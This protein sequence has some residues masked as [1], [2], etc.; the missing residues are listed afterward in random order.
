M[1]ENALDTVLEAKKRGEDHRRQKEEKWK[2]YYKLYRSYLEDKR[3]NKANL[4][5]PYMFS[6]IESVVPRLTDTIFRQ[7]PYLR[8][9]PRTLEDKPHAEA[10]E[11]LLDYQIDLM[12]FKAIC[13]SWFKEATIYGTGIAK[14]GWK[15][16]YQTVVDKRLVPINNFMDIFRAGDSG[17]Y[18]TYEHEIIAYDGPFIECVD[19]FDYYVDPYCEDHRDARWAVHKTLKDIDYLKDMQEKGIYE[20]VDEVEDAGKRVDHSATKRLMGIQQATQPGPD[21]GMNEISEYWEKDRVITVANDIV[22][23]R[24]APNPYHHKRLP[25][26][27]VVNT[28]VP[29]EFWGIGEVEPSE[30]LQNELNTLRN[31]AIDNLSLA[32]NNMF[33]VSEQA[34][35]D[36]DDL[37][38]R[39]NGII[40][41]NKPDVNEALMQIGPSRVSP[42]SFNME[43]VIKKDIQETSGV[44]QYVK[45]ME[46]GR[47]ATATEIT[48]LQREANYRF[49]QKI[50]NMIDGLEEVGEMMVALNQQFIEEPQ[51]IRIAGE[52]GFEFKTI[53]P[54]EIMGQFDIQIA[55][56]ALEPNA[57][58]QVR[59]Q[60][61]LEA[62][63][64]VGQLTGVPSMTLLE[65]ALKT[66]DMPEVENVI[67]EIQQQVQQAQQREQAESGMPQQQ[68][69]QPQQPSPETQNPQGILQRILGAV[70][71]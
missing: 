34:G 41:T 36:A 19:I 15:T 39:P 62:I 44:V 11:A 64:I 17:I 31:Q 65:E 70:R 45:G 6:T 69:Q 29:K 46:P 59:R 61:L 23:L 52:K 71:R 58:R 47:Q 56:T 60:Q 21:E 66:Y 18:E 54:D 20:N 22:V 12:K 48:S 28:Q 63:Q 57:D 35:I 51:A 7:K 38:F 25:F 5:V 37:T 33:L 42:S 49:I 2:E 43:E 30:S 24:D 3:E 55:S 4:F 32:I 67:A 1:A 10:L 14:I 27:K 50:R 16:K 8:P 68:P 40:W 26:V 13:T 9:M 53:A